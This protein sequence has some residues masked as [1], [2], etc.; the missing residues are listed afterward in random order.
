MAAALFNRILSRDEFRTVAE[1]KKATGPVRT[2]YNG[3][4]Q[5][6]T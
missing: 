4:N 6:L 1:V 3:I 5:S 2:E